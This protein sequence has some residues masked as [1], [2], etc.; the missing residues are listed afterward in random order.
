VAYRPFAWF[1][2][3]PAVPHSYILRE[4]IKEKQG[5]ASTEDLRQVMIHYRTLFE[6]LIAEPQAVRP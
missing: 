4:S 1:R 5:H 3:C 2:S 6:E